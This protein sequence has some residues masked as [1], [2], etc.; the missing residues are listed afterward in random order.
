M[1]LKFMAQALIL[2][3]LSDCFSK[4]TDRRERLIILFADDLKVLSFF[5]STRVATS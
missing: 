5:H 4:V 2:L 1:R 3:K